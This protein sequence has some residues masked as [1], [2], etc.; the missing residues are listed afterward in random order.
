MDTSIL[1]D[2]G[3]TGA[4][5]KVFLTLIELGSSNAGPVVEKSGL[6]NAVVH[7]AFHSLIEKGLVTYVLEGKKKQYQAVNP[8]LLLD[9]IEEK[10]DRLKT[11][12]PE[13]IAKQSIAKKKPEAAIY[14]GIRGVKEL[15]NLMLEINSKEYF[16]YGGGLKANKLL[17]DYFWAGFHNRRI[18]KRITA[19]LIFHSSLKYWGKEI[20]RKKIT[21][22]RYT[23]KEFEEFTETVICGNRVGIIIYL[24][25]PFGFL[26]EEEKAAKSYKRFFQLL[27]KES[28]K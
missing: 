17:G 5:I 15:L 24:D 4:E 2:L 21:T 10:K 16:G 18:K 28:V 20:S 12:L 22:V 9:F 14:R 13:L 23:E 1:E 26:I 3:L 7:R 25:K 6:Q 19:K 27:W 11:I 8:K